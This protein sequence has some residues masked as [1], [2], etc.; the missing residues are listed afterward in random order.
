MDLPDEILVRVMKHL[1]DPRHL[2]SVA[3][4]CK[5]WCAVSSDREVQRLWWYNHRP[6]NLGPRPRPRGLH[7]VGCTLRACLYEY[8]IDIT[9]PDDGDTRCH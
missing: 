3:L 2:R 4:V 9:T 1:G 7:C 8:K 5:R 6:R